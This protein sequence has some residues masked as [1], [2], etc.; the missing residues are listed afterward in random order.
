MRAVRAAGR[1]IA[2]PNGTRLSIKLLRERLNRPVFMVDRHDGVV[3]NDLMLSVA[4]LCSLCRDGSGD[5][6]DGE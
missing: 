2:R 3:R 6:R 1:F 5:G 4:T